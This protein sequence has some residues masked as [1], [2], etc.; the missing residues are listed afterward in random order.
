[1]ILGL[2]EKLLIK[3][4]LIIAT[5]EKDFKERVSFWTKKASK[6]DIKLGTISER[7][8]PKLRTIGTQGGK[9]IIILVG[10]IAS[11]LFSKVRIISV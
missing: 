4:V 10:K 5:E 9:Y 1:M 11:E 6:H 2:S 3:N 8:L 7:D